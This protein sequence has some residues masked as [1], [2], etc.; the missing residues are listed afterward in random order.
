MVRPSRVTIVLVTL[1][2]FAVLLVGQAARVQL[3]EGK[4][5]AE[6]ARRQQ[7]RTGA[8]SAPR[9]KILDASGNV[10]ADA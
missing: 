6:R 10:L 4:E 7:F 1:L 5:W 3:F 2:V 9:G 8:V